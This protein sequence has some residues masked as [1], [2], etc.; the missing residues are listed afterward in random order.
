MDHG[1]LF[2]NRTLEELVHAHS[3]FNAPFSQRSYCEEFVGTPFH[4]VGWPP[5]KMPYPLQTSRQQRRKK[6]RILK[7]KQKKLKGK[8][9]SK[10]HS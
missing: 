7:K 10:M 5:W 3:N 9:S 4:Y 8:N 2:D 1:S 6:E